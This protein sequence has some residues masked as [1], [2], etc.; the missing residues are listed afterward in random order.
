MFFYSLK[1]QLPELDMSHTELRKVAVTYILDNLED[2][3]GFTEGSLEEYINQISQ[4]GE[5]ADNPIIQ[6]LAN[7][8]GISI[9]IYGID[10][11]NTMIVSNE[12]FSRT[13]N[14]AYTGNHYLS[15]EPIQPQEIDEEEIPEILGGTEVSILSPSTEPTKSPTSR[16]EV[17]FIE[18]ELCDTGRA[19]STNYTVTLIED[20]LETEDTV[21]VVCLGIIS[22]G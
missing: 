18:S 4:N 21:D 2:F 10:G 12:A 22:E 3:Q 17:N 8:L 1:K 7:A 5:W 14:I 6:A 19:N 20:L 15:V 11:A 16:M 13:V 9:N